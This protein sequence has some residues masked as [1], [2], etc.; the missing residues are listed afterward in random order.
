M[1]AS[2]G[3]AYGWR[4]VRQQL[5][6]LDCSPAEM[7]RQRGGCVVVYASKNGAM[8]A[9]AIVVRPWPGARTGL[10]P[11][12]RWP[13][14]VKTRFCAAQLQGYI[15][16][17][18]P[19]SHARHAKR[20]GCALAHGPAAVLGDAERAGRGQYRVLPTAR[21]GAERF[22][23]GG[24]YVLHRPLGARRGAAGDFCSPPARMRWM[25]CW[26]KQP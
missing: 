16:T 15:C 26:R 14:A 10:P 24:L 25:R 20:H 19:A 6:R 18:T 1:L 9:E 5:A 3:I 11:Q 8:A 2:R 12:A 22:A 7:T 4:A 23:G 13:F 21:G 17:T